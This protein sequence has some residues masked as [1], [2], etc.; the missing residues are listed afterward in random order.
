[1]DI[2]DDTWPVWAILGSNDSKEV[3]VSESQFEDEET[4]ERRTKVRGTLARGGG[5]VEEWLE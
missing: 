3:V 4:Q 5:I 2:V 1:V